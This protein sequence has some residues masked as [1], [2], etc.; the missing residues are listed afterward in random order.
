MNLIED[1]IEF[2]ERFEIP[3][4]FTQYRVIIGSKKG[5]LK[6]LNPTKPFKLTQVK[7]DLEELKITI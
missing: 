7:F 6:Y 2:C 5:V 3:Y 4:S 1:F